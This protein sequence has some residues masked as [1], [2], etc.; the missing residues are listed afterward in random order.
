MKDL[1]STETMQVNSVMEAMKSKLIR[2]ATDQELASKFSVI[3][4]MI[5]LRPQHIPN[6]EESKALF[7]YVRT[8]YPLRTLDEL[9]LAF[10]N[11]VEQKY[12][13]DVKFYDQFTLINFNM[14]MNAYRQYVNDLNSKLREVKPPVQDVDY[15]KEEDIK[16]FLQKTNL[17]TKNLL[18]IPVYMFDIMEELGY[19]NQSETDKIILFRTATDIYEAKL[20]KDAEYFDKFAIGKLNRFLKEKQDNFE[21]IDDITVNE[22]KT[23][24]KRLSCLNENKKYQRSINSTT[25]A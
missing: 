1:N 6:P 9:W 24:Y 13:E 16:E 19:I 18:L 22:V 25:K 20:R 23:I 4:F 10:K 14:I 21:N 15:S 12:C 7:A 5:G 2:D 17:T 8:T 11:Y 3:Y